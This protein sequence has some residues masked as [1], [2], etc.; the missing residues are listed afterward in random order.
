MKG[1]KEYQTLIGCLLIAAAVII[2]G[3]IVAEAVKY[4][5]ADLAKSLTSAIGVYVG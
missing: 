2:A 5:T 3:V 1:L 4:G